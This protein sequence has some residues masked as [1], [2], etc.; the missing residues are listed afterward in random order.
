MFSLIFE[1]VDVI[2]LGARLNRKHCSCFCTIFQLFFIRDF[3]ILHFCL[4]FTD[5]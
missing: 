3:F 2:S 1:F 4:F 5:F